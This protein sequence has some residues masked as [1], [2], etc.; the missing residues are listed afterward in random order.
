M[1]TRVEGSEI[2]QDN[3]VRKRAVPS[4]LEDKTAFRKQTNLMKVQTILDDKGDDK[5]KRYV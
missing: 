1:K 5:R 4:N 3:E 2:I